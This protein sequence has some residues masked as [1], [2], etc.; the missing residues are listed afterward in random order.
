MPLTFSEICKFT[1][2]Y[3][4][5]FANYE[6]VILCFC[7]NLSKLILIIDTRIQYLSI[8]KTEGT[9]NDLLYESENSFKYFDKQAIPDKYASKENCMHH[10]QR[11]FHLKAS[12]NIK[13]NK[14]I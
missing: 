9:Q 7:L 12:L 6:N 2:L 11:S 13:F 14:V 4:N 1:L 10:A 5:V 3:F 8:N